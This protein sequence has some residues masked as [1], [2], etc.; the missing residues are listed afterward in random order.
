MLIYA[1]YYGKTQEVFSLSCGI[2]TSASSGLKTENIGSLKKSMSY[3]KK[4]V[5]PI[6]EI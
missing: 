3:I 6:C 1:V 4:R 2:I 5:N